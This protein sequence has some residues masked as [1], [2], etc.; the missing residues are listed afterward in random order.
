MSRLHPAAFNLLDAE[1][2]RC[3]HGSSAELAY[4]FAIARLQR[5]CDTAGPPVAAQE[6]RKILIDL[7][8]QISPTALRQAAQLN[9]AQ[10]HTETIGADR[11]GY[12]PAGLAGFRS[13]FHRFT[14]T[15]GLSL[16]W[17]TLLSAVG[18]FAF[19][20]SPVPLPGIAAM[21]T[22]MNTAIA[23]MSLPRS[24]ELVQTAKTFATITQQSMPAKALSVQEWQRVIEQWQ[25]SIDLL[26]QV[27]PQSAEH[28]TAQQLIRQ[29][30][31]QQVQAQ[32]HL[33]A[34]KASATALQVAKARVRWFIPKAAQMNPQ[35]KA[36][37]I[38]QIEQQL[39]PV[40]PNT[41][42]YASRQVILA[43]MKQKMR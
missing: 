23:E 20:R 22:A 21:N 38:H 8:P 1:L 25:E 16:T 4:Q 2:Q 5:L 6:L 34:E 18:L 29:Y 10:Y 33:R 35:E 13:I 14:L 39:K 37:A 17:A 19:P 12:R 32:Q 11:N 43:E 3:L 28:A 30:Q 26:Q 42:G 41:T 31:H 40:I 36:K 9:T 7:A 27:S 24:G 15:W